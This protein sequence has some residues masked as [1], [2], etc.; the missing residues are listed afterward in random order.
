MPR[1][2]FR[3]NR[4]LKLSTCATLVLLLAGAALFWKRGSSEPLPAEIDRAVQKVK[5]HRDWWDGRLLAFVG[6]CAS[7]SRIA[8]K[9]LQ[10]SSQHTLTGLIQRGAAERELIRMGTNAW[11]AVPVFIEMLGEK[12]WDLRLTAFQIL[13]QINAEQC[14]CFFQFRAR[15]NKRTVETLTR[16][17]QRTRPFQQPANPNDRLFAVRCLA[18]CRDN[19]ALTTLTTLATSDQDHE[20]RAAAIQSL[21]SRAHSATFQLFRTYLMNTNEWSDVRAAA[22]MALGKIRD[23]RA[24]RS[25]RYG[26]NDRFALVRVCSAGALAQFGANE[27]EI[28]PVFRDGAG[29]KLA[30]VRLATLEAIQASNIRRTAAELLIQKLRDDPDPRIRARA[31]KYL[32]P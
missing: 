27:G 18:L 17:L 25:L 8:R 26:L 32:A 16:T 31:E 23:P 14:P 6:R 10:T 15:S 28:V 2:I 20:L 9:L 19:E 12:S 21:G 24:I 30:S 22:A 3:T 4:W 29:H 13:S 11:P 7:G 1:E 5:P